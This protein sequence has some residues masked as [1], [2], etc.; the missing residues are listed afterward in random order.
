MKT[1]FYAQ[2]MRFISTRYSKAMISALLLFTLQG[3]CFG[4][5]SSYTDV[6]ISGDSVVAYGA[7]LDDYSHGQH[8]NTT[9]VT[10]SSPGGGSAQSSGGDSATSFISITE[11]GFYSANT[12]HD[13]WC[14][15]TQQTFPSGGSS[16]STQACTD[17]C[18]PC[19]VSRHG[20]EIACG[21]LLGG[22]ETAALNK[23]NADIQTCDDRNYC[24]PNHPEY[25]QQQCDQCKNTAG[26]VFAGATAACGLA[27]VGCRALITP[28]CEVSAIKKADCSACSNSPF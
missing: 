23:W 20:K 19:R 16:N 13:S 21:A 5:I 15:Y 22:C 24:K 9:V 25:S 17:S 3:I 1:N 14:P 26:E 4:Q 28:D 2:N 27:Y 12:S 11:D 10:L 8:I 7:V 18:T 6:G